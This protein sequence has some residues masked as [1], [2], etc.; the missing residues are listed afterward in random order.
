MHRIL[1]HVSSRVASHYV[2]SVL[3]GIQGELKG[4]L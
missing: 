1:I 4:T 2:A 3:T